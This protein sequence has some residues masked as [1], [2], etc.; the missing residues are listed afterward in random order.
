MPVIAS[1]VHT[2]A[3]FQCLAVAGVLAHWHIVA[4]RKL[5][6]V[7]FLAPV[8]ADTHLHGALTVTAVSKGHHR[9]GL[10]TIGGTQGWRHQIRAVSGDGCLRPSTSNRVLIVSRHVRDRGVRS[11]SASPQF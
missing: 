7:Q 6:E 8:H 9:W 3:V 4:G 11:P 10:V 1:G 5:R 2:L